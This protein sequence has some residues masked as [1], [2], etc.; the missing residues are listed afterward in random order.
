MIRTALSALAIFAITTCTKAEANEEMPKPR[1]E[2]GSTATIPAAGTDNGLLALTLVNAERYDTEI[3]CDGKVVTSAVRNSAAA[4]RFTVSANEGR[5][6]R[7]GWIEVNCGNVSRRVDVK[8]A[9]NEVPPAIEG[10]MG[11]FELPGKPRNGDLICYAHDRLPS[12]N[13]RRNFSFCF[14]AD[15]HAS[16]WVAYPLHNCYLGEMDRTN[17]YGFD[18]QF[19][20][21]MGDN[22]GEEPAMQANISAAYYSDGYKEGTQYSRGHQL[23]SADRTASYNDNVSTFFATNM[24]PQ[25]Q[26]LNGGAWA[27]LEDLVRNSW[28]CSDTL[29][30]VTGAIFDKGHK[31]ALD[32]QGRGKACSVPTH[33][34]KAL[35][36]TKE[37]KSGKSVAECTADELKCI[38]FVFTHDTSRASMK[39]YASDACSVAELEEMTGETFFVNVP[40]APKSKCDTSEWPGLTQQARKN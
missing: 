40:N 7:T 28:I 19:A 29:Y 20:E 23:P 33:Y 8:Q 12:D 30:V 3:M 36:R 5:S 10:R 4:I 31:Q 15:H 21:D 18:W 26:S 34:Y 37:G 24:T 27:R 13:S 39:V 35:L 11:W 9:R 38:G 6:E 25:L 16:M 17:K 1:I 22:K 14:S 2:L 32:N